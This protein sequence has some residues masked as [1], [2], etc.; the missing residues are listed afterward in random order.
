MIHGPGFWTEW[1]WGYALSVANAAW[2]YRVHSRCLE[3]EKAD[4][5][6][7]MLALNGVR[8]AILL[9]AL[10][11][12]RFATPLAFIPFVTVVLVGYF[13]FL[14]VEMVRVAR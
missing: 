12:V 11:L 5:L 6:L 1:A 2:A 13:F 14:A 8:C 4:R 7:W 10:L 3:H 9:I